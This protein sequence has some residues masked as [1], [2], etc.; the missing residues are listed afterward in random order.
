LHPQKIVQGSCND[1]D[2]NYTNEN[3]FRHYI[4]VRLL[5]KAA[6]GV[7]PNSGNLLFELLYHGNLLWFCAIVLCR[8][9]SGPIGQEQRREDAF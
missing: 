5:R 4:S 6:K 2:D 9:P 3:G 8:V 7:F 1:E